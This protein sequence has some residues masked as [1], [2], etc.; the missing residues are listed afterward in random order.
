MEPYGCHRLVAG[1]VLREFHF[2]CR[3]LN[4]NVNHVLGAKRNRGFD[5]GMSPAEKTSPNRVN[6]MYEPPLMGN[7]TLT[8]QD[9]IRQ[10]QSDAGWLGKR[11]PDPQRPDFGR[12]QP[13]VGIVETVVWLAQ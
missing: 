3:K 4:L 7:D 13:S 1:N 6:R 11:L 10:T 5:R 9:W 2:K 12:H 8:S